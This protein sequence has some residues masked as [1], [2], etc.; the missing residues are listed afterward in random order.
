V[1]EALA[2]WLADDARVRAYEIVGNR[3]QGGRDRGAPAGPLSRVECTRHDEPIV[4]V[5]SM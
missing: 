2:A 5:M 4:S 3:E 1:A